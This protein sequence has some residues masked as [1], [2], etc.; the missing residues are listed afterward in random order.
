MPASDPPPSLIRMTYTPPT[1]GSNG[2]GFARAAAFVVGLF[3][4]VVVAMT[5]LFILIGFGGATES[6]A[7]QACRDW[8]ETRL[9]WVFGLFALSFVTALVALVRPARRPGGRRTT[10]TLPLVLAAIAIQ[11]TAFALSQNGPAA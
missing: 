9:P 11:A 4:F 10:V 8:Y 1:P 3:A 7:N 5:D 2:D 6:C